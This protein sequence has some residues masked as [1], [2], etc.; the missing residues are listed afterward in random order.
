[1][2][3]EFGKAKN[4]KRVVL[5]AIILFSFFS[6][7]ISAFLMYIAIEK[8]QI[9]YLAISL[10]M[11]LFVFIFPAIHIRNLYSFPPAE[12]D[13]NFLVINQPLQNR[14]AYTLKNI[15]WVRKF[16][17]SIIFMHNGF[18]VLFNVGSL[19]NQEVS[20]IVEL[21]KSANK[22]IHATSA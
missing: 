18:P 7:P 19:N 10:L 9:S 8:M 6:M 1:M 4:W 21:I 16:L 22:P 3:Q 2:Y 20:K 11:S 12:M 15:T 13:E 5:P 14:K 17:K